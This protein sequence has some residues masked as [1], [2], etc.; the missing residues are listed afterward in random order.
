M[1]PYLL[2]HKTEKVCAQDA[3]EMMIRCDDDV[4]QIDFNFAFTFT[5]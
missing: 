2:R 5:N 4:C 3:H 1:I